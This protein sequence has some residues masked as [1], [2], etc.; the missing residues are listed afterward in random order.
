MVLLSKKRLDSCFLSFYEFQ[1]FFIFFLIRRCQKVPKYFCGS[2][3]LG[4][5]SRSKNILLF[6]SDNSKKKKT[7]SNYPITGWSVSLSFSS[8]L[9][10]TIPF[11]LWIFQA[12]A[13]SSLDGKNFFTNS[14]MQHPRL[15]SSPKISLSPFVR[16]SFAPP[17]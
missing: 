2:F 11:F 17:K 5:Y 4:Q 8:S 13:H 6:F 7:I 15:C 3:F 16:P 14:Q 9:E 12:K 1:N 10:K